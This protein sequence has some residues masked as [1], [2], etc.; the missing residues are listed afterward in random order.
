MQELDVQPTNPTPYTP[1]GGT[2]NNNPAPGAGGLPSLSGLSNRMNPMA[3]E[4]QNQGR[5]EDSMLVHMTPGEVNSLRGLAQ[6]FGGDLTTN[7]STGL[8]E[9]GWL[10]KLLPTLIGAAGMLIPGVAPWML[11][12]GVGAGQA[13]LTGDLNK[14]LMAGL[15]AFG[16][17]SLAGAAGVGSGASSAIAPVTDAAST[18]TTAAGGAGA[19]AAGAGSVV[20]AALDPALAANSAINSSLGLGGNAANAIEGAVKVTGNLPGAISQAAGQNAAKTGLAGFAQQFGQ[21]AAEGLPSGMLSKYAP[22]AAGLGTLSAVS[23]AT[24]PDL[25]KYER[26]EDKWKYEGPYYPMPRRI[27]PRATGPEGEGEISFFDVTN[28]VGYLTATG[29]RRGYAEGGAAK[30]S[31]KAMEGDFDPSAFDPTKF[32]QKQLTQGMVDPNTGFRTGLSHGSTLKQMGMGAGTTSNLGDKRFVLNEN[33][34]WEY[35]PL[36]AAPATGGDDKPQVSFPQPNTGGGGGVTPGGGTG[37]TLTT[38]T[39]TPGATQSGFGVETLGSTYTPNFTPKDD[40]T[41]PKNAPYTLGSQMTAALPGL[42]SQ[43]RTSP[44]AITAS[45]GYEGGS[46]SERIRAMAKA[47]AAAKGD[48]VKPTTEIDFGLPKTSAINSTAYAASGLPDFTNM[49]PQDIF[50]YYNRPGALD[51][52]SRARGG[53]VNMDDGSFVIDA[54]TVSELGNGSSNAGIEFLE[55]LGGRAVRGPGDGVSDSVPANIGGTQEARVARDEVIFPAAVVKKL[56]GAK[57]LYALMD[58]AHA[59]RKKAK[60]G[61]DTK[62]AKGLG[63]LA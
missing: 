56:G 22:Y 45:R 19:G 52:P 3:Q 55:R 42:T 23:D 51:G 37:A 38:P 35:A 28:P 32:T 54:R 15:Q 1:A 59:A 62:V 24:A 50:N 30:G 4:L 39:L 12:A 34:E 53:S 31:D 6:K 57:K 48:A 41:T 20:P 25:K 43:F 26:E 47:N 46:P 33:Y 36:P 2:Y 21:T 63:A 16:G 8:P 9:A 27:S 29:E 58:K 5:G 10:G 11:A 13:A 40:Y 49:T 7:P 60:R 61:Q 18:A 14:G 17:A 44:G